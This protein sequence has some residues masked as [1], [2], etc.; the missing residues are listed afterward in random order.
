MF[1]MRSLNHKMLVIMTL[2]LRTLL[3]WISK[4]LQD[5][6][7]GTYSSQTN[8]IKLGMWLIR[9]IQIYVLMPRIMS[10]RW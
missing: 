1:T 7:Y 6:V 10:K 2:K 9:K 5:K 4:R 3:L 8:K